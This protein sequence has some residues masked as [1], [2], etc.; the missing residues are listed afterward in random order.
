M[1]IYQ[2]YIEFST[3]GENDV[4][5]I[6]KKVGNIVKRS[7]LREGLVNVFVIGSTAAISTMEYEPGLVYD[8]TSALSRIAPADIY[9]KHHERWG[10][11]NGRS[12]VKATLIG[13]SLTVPFLDGKL[14]LG[15]WQQIIFIELDTRPRN[16][17]ILV[18][19]LGQ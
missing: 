14:V 18:T 17:R 19:I 5:D 7:G 11:D 1:A 2:E 6:T 4:I 13:P 12:H 10:D 3:K 8:L 9:Y 16:R 15:T